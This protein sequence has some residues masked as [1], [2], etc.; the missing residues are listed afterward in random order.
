MIAPQS[1]RDGSSRTLDSLANPNLCL[2]VVADGLE[3]MS[4]SIK[5]Y[6]AAVF[7]LDPQVLDGGGSA[8]SLASWQDGD[9]VHPLITPLD[10]LLTAPWKLL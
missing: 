6:L 7:E 10:Q 8:A 5:A 4:V 3:K 1:P 2:L 9:Q